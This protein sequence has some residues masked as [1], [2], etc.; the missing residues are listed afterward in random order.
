LQAIRLAYQ[1][2]GLRKLAGFATLLDSCWS[3]PHDVIL[4]PVRGVTL[5]A[6]CGR[7]L[8]IDAHGAVRLR[9]SPGVEARVPAHHI[10]R[11]REV[12]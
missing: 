10:H 1:E 11:L 9:T 6:T 7:F 8:G 5:A 12:T 2:F 4:E 3:E